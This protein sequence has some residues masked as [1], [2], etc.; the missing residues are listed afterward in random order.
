MYLSVLPCIAL[1]SPALH[2]SFKFC[3]S[4]HLLILLCFALIF[5]PCIF[6]NNPALHR[7]FNALIFS[8]LNYCPTTWGKFTLTLLCDIQRCL[9][10]TAKV[11]HDGHFMKSGHLT[12]P[13]ST[14]GWGNISER[15][16]HYEPMQVFKIQNKLSLPKGI[17][18]SSRRAAHR[19]SI[20]TSTP[21]SEV[22]SLVQG[23]FQ[24]QA[25]KHHQSTRWH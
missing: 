4:L 18:F 21:S 15:P 7:T 22:H 11:P 2:C 20:V 19:R 23:C 24:S 6:R 5:G 13:L 1:I 10:I 14:L 12:P 17:V 8:N 9:N 3:P 16:E 25:Q